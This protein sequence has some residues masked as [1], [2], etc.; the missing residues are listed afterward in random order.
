MIEGLKS[1]VEF[2]GCLIAAVLVLALLLSLFSAAVLIT[3]KG[4]L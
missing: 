1:S 4:R 3:R 2:A